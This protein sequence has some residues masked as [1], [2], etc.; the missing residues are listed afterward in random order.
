MDASKKVKSNS[1][2]FVKHPNKGEKEVNQQ[3]SKGKSAKSLPIPIDIP[4][5]LM[6]VIIRTITHLTDYA[7]VLLLK[8]LRVI[9][10]VGRLIGF[11]TPKFEVVRLKEY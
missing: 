5:S 2:E 6:K 11:G 8:I 7:Q 4:E 10:P 3:E 1:R 9:K